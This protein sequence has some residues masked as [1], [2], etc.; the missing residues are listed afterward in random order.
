M[1]EVEKAMAHAVQ[2]NDTLKS[3]SFTFDQPSN[4]FSFEDCEVAGVAFADALKCNGSLGSFE[5][6]DIDDDIDDDVAAPVECM[7]RIAENFIHALEQNVSI[8]SFKCFGSSSR[9]VDDI[10][11]RNE[12]LRRQRH[13]LTNV[14]RLSADTS[15]GSLTERAFRVE[16]L[17]FFLP[18]GCKWMPVEF[19]MSSPRGGKRGVSYEQSQEEV[20]ACA[21]S[22]SSCGEIM[23]K[24]HPSHAKTSF[25]RFRALEKYTKNIS[26]I[27][28]STDPQK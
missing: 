19:L 8:Q 18:P 15:F 21:P 17:S 2:H 1:W 23:Q 20:V 3:F 25:L 6:G 9:S 14:A 12:L 4:G 22:P 24:M 11:A 7:E 10:I 26:K 5:L 16:I 27:N 28:T 13:A